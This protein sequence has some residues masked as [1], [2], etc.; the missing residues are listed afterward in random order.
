MDE[1]SDTV[2]TDTDVQAKAATEYD[3]A[4]QGDPVFARDTAT[5]NLYEIGTVDE[6]HKT[7]F[8]WESRLVVEYKINGYEKPKTVPAPSPENNTG[9]GAA[10]KMPGGGSEI[11]TGRG[12]WKIRTL[13]THPPHTSPM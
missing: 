6:W 13:L 7:C 2:I 10:E 12:V 1:L 4:K 3:G 5:G 11:L 8:G 9:G